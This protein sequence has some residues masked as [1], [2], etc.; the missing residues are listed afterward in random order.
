M[1]VG[2]GY[3]FVLGTCFY[4]PFK[5]SLPPSVS[6]YILSPSKAPSSMR[7]NPTFHSKTSHSSSIISKICTPLPSRYIHQ[8]T[9]PTHIKLPARSSLHHRTLRCS[10]STQ[11]NNDDEW[12]PITRPPFIPFLRVFS[13]I[14]TLSLGPGYYKPDTL[15]GRDLPKS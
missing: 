9:I 1:S 15:T 11:T 7:L 12:A 10:S 6:L 13:D 2:L 3:S 5:T 14:G 4:L 8:F